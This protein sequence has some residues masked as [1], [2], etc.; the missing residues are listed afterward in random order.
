VGKYGVMY[1]SDHQYY[2]RARHYDP[3]IGRFYSEDPIW[4]TNLYPY[5]DNNPIMGIDPKGES[6]NPIYEDPNSDY[7]TLLVGRLPDYAIEYE[8]A[9]ELSY[10]IVIKGNNGKYIQKKV[11]Y[12]EYKNWSNS[13][14]GSK[15]EDAVQIVH[16]G[17]NKVK[18]TQP[19]VLDNPLRSSAGTIQQQ[20]STPDVMSQEHWDYQLANNSGGGKLSKGEI[21]VSQKII[22]PV[23]NFYDKGIHKADDATDKV[24]SWVVNLF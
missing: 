4:S 15:A 2:M 17:N 3:T 20:K 8:G 24:I 16:V 13:Q 23:G 18:P 5:A 9:K 1:L 21:W 22:Q 11:T 12:N 6:N 7:K 14:K 19:Y 10:A